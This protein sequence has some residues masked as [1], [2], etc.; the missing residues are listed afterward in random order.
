MKREYSLPVYAVSP[1]GGEYLSVNYERLDRNRPEYGYGTYT[2]SSLKNQNVDGIHIVDLETAEANLIISISSLLQNLEAQSP[3]DHFVNH[4][5]FSPNGSRFVFIHRWN[6]QGGRRSRLYTADLSGNKQ[7]LMDSGVVSHYCWLDSSR[8]LVWGLSEENGYGYHLIN[9]LTGD[10]Q[11]LRLMNSFGDG[12]PSI[13]PNGR[14]IVTDTYPDR[15]RQRA[16]ILFDMNENEIDILGRFF[17]P[18]EYTGATRCDLH[19]RWGPSGTSLSFDSTHEGTR[20]SYV[21]DV[22][23]VVEK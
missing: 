14:Y 6:A 8:L 22:E 21:L 15:R 2:T 9:V 23:E 17:E 10:T 3:D 7:L 5:R 11:Y 12:H 16:L 19:P 18:L 1:D 20:K 4:A 13:S